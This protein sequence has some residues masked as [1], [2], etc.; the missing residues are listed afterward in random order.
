[1][2]FGEDSAHFAFPKSAFTLFGS[3]KSSLCYDEHRAE[4]V[5]KMVNYEK[6]AKEANNHIQKESLNLEDP[7]Y[8]H[9][10]DEYA[11]NNHQRKRPG[12]RSRS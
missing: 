7:V 9:E 5:A 12:S 10:F 1:M 11:G 8:D 6:F 4:K 2:I 3:R